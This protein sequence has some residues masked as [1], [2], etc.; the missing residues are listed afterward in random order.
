MWLVSSWVRRERE[1]CCDAFVVTR[2]NRPHAYAELLVALAAQMPRSVLF[3]PA[4]SSAMAAGPLRTR[5]RRIL[6]LDD[7]P[8][9]VSG[10]SFALMLAAL[11]VA[12]TLAVLYVPTIGQAE[13][14]TTEATESTESKNELEKP[15]VDTVTND[16]WPTG[17]VFPS[18]K[19]GEISKRAYELLGL[20]I[21]PATDDEL[22]TVRQKGFPSGLKVLNLPL[23]L[24]S[25]R[26]PAILVSLGRA[27]IV[28]FAALDHVVTETARG[29]MHSGVTIVELGGIAG[30]REF[31]GSV[32]L[33]PL[34][35]VQIKDDELFLSAS[36]A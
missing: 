9:L 20:K 21:V 14:S 3:H 29:R 4:A 32:R 35:E 18:P 24:H 22:K 27:P 11:L 23:G 5:I 17:V 28:D 7:D 31:K 36:D 26:G 1:A 19:E 30:S 16:D 10:K 6:Q 33:R 8:M 13:E 2:T 25:G 15:T 12:A 34:E